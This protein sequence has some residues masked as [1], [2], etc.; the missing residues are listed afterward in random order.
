MMNL[1]FAGVL[2]PIALVFPK[3]KLIVVSIYSIKLI[4]SFL[5]IFN[6]YTNAH[7][8]KCKIKIQFQKS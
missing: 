8:I 2:V 1:R 5:I 4:N 7:N 3:L 6:V